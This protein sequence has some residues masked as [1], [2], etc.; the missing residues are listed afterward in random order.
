MRL[1]TTKVVSLPWRQHHQQARS[2][3]SPLPAE[4]DDDDWAHALQAT[5]EVSTAHS[6]TPPPPQQEPMRV[7]LSPHHHTHHGAPV[8]PAA[9]Q[10]YGL[11]PPDKAESCHAQVSHLCACIG[12]PCLRQCVHGASIA[13]APVHRHAGWR[14][15]VGGGDGA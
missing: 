6:P 10:R 12:S 8:S 11:P 15:G 13:A 2:P 4:V 1:L 14:V 7:V 5:P 9:A 3:S